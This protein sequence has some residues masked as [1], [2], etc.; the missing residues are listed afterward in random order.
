MD[1]IKKMGDSLAGRFFQHHL[2]PLDL[3]ELKGCVLFELDEI[4]ERLLSLGGFPEPFLQGSESEYHR[5]RQSHLSII[6][7]QDL[8]DLET[9]QNILSIERLIQL[10]RHCVGST[11]SY[12]SLARDLEHDSKTVKC[13]LSI[14]ENMY[15]IF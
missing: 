9:V 7:R 11:V 14:L 5:W 3:K 1:I 15:I 4:F 2:F 12:A 10:L 8:L 6:L 13:W